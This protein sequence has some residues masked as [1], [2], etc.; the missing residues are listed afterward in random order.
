MMK[1]EPVG[2]YYGKS[3]NDNVSQDS[4]TDDQNTFSSNTV[5]WFNLHIAFT[6]EMTS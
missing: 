5:I 3:S 1:Y 4:S 6:V 2:S